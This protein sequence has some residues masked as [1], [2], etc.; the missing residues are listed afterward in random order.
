M[1]DTETKAKGEAM[2][3]ERYTFPERLTHF[4]H[5]VAM[6]ILIITGLKIYAG[7]NFMT[8]HN[9][10][11]LHT[12]AV[13]VFLVVNWILVP[14]NILSSECKGCAKGGAGHR[15]MHIVHRYVF[16]PT[17]IRRLKQIMLNYVGKGKYPA[18]TVYDTRGGH[19][20][21]KLH[22][23]MQLLL[24]FE[25]GA[26]LFAALSGI[27]LYNIEW[28]LFGLPISAWILSASGMIAPLLDMSAMGFL[29]TLHLA[30]MY[31]F[32]FELVV[33]VGILEFDP[34]VWKYYKAVFLTGKEDL[35]DEAY[36][37]VIGKK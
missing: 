7:W 27:V 5:L 35:S 20:D 32:V 2:I 26:I 18:F 13:P 6:F 23:T 8:F 17:D 31:W 34:K 14:Y 16:G 19:Y 24:F 29:R 21:D 1:E 4:V 12:I 25:G 15:M 9:A 10:R 30:M 36:V 33:H 22:P 28:A 3:V 11:S 37:E